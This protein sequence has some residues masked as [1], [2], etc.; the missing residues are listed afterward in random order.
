[1]NY[2]VLFSVIIIA[3]SVVILLLP[4]SSNA[5]EGF[6]TQRIKEKAEAAAKAAA[7][8]AAEA[9]AEALAAEPSAA[10]Q[11]NTTITAGPADGSSNNEHLLDNLLMKY[12][13]LANVV[14]N[15]DKTA[16]A[17]SSTTTQKNGIA[18]TSGPYKGG[19]NDGN[20]VNGSSCSTCKLQVNDNTKCV[21]PGCHSSD[22]RYLPF[23]DDDGYNFAE[24]CFYYN[25]D[26]GKVIPGMQT[27]P[28]GYYCP[29]ITQGSRYDASSSDPCYTKPDP[30]NIKSNIIDYSKYVKIDSMCSNNKQKSEKDAPV[31]GTTTQ[32]HI[33]SHKHAGAVNVYHHH[34]YHGSKKHSNDS[35]GN[36]GSNGSNDKNGNHSRNAYMEPVA[37]AEVL[38]FL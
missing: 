25:P 10:G 17:V 35:N 28:P 30:T 36:N 34:M 19:G 38:G 6:D 15:R 11:R 3:V 5:E 20:E 16:T 18:S 22:D 14:E 2:F 33:H 24:G 37:G 12:D 31:D 21:L 23:P 29:P 32:Q 13:Q 9:A 7:K 8:A 27:Q 1:M 26:N 4:S